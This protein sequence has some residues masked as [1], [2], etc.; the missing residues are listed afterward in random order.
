VSG[1]ILNNV[2]QKGL[3]AR[4]SSKLISQLTSSA[5]A[6]ADMDLSD[7]DKK[8]ISSVYMRGLHV[9][10]VSYALLISF[11]FVSTLFLRDYGLGTK[12]QSHQEWE[13]ED[14]AYGQY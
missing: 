3:K 4:F 7:D 8:L 14:S 6:L 5:F 12:Q 9:V 2:L 1:A 10:F 13:E 11:L